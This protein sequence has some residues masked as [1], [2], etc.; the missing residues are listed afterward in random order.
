MESSVF[1]VV[2]SQS[3]Q[4]LILTCEHANADIPSEYNNLSLTANDLDTHIA[5]DKGCKEITRLLAQKLGCFA[6]MG[7]YS[8]LLIDLNRRVDEDELIVEVSD[9]VEVIGNKNLSIEERQHRINKYY[10]P[11]YAEIN[12]QIDYLKSQGKAPI[13]FSIHS[14]TPQLKG[15]DYRPWHAGILYHNPSNLATYLYDELQNTDKNVGE[16]VPYD[17]RKYNTG[18][19]VICGEENGF[20]YALIEIRDDE[21]DNLMEGANEWSDILANIL[22]QYLQKQ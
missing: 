13:V 3:D 21:F 9:K 5:R 11:Y 22:K 19:A 4:V 1:E 20:D 16:N 6:I 8:R 17:L 12:K 15:G 14:Y 18:A 10:H 2:N 7:N